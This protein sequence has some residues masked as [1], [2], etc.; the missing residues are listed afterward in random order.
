MAYSVYVLNRTHTKALKDMTP[1]EAWSGRKPHIAH[2]R[3][4]GCVAY[5][6]VVKGHIKKLEDRSMPLVHLGIEKGSKAYMHL[7]PDSGKVYVSRD[8]VF[9]EN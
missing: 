7:D 3:G 5:M 1:F 2:L 4:F 8:F 9:E 6:K